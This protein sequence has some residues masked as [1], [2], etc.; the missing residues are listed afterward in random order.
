MDDTTRQVREMYQ[1][2]PYPSGAPALRSSSD[3]RL[4]LSYGSVARSEARQMWA[5]DAGCGRG[6]GTIGHA[7]TQPDINFVGIDITPEALTD[8][9]AAADKRN[10]KN[11][12]FQEI[13]LMTLE[14][15]QVPPG[16]FDVIYS[17]GVLHHLT[18][19][20]QGLI[21]LREVLAPHGVI[22]LMVYGS[23]GRHPLYRLVSAIDVLAPRTLPLE[24]RLAAGRALAKSA[25]HDAIGAGP[26]TDINTIPDV[27]FVDRYLHVNETSYSITELFSLA[28]QAGLGFL[29]WSHPQDWDVTTLIEEGPSRAAA[30][31]LPP[32]AQ[33]RLVEQLAWRPC[34]EVILT[35][36]G[37]TLRAPP[38]R[39]TLEQTV[40]AMSPEAVIATSTR[41]LW[42]DQRIE[43]VSL[44]IRHAEPFT[45]EHP[46]L[47]HACYLLKDQTAPFDG[48][49]FI[50]ICGQEGLA[51]EVAASALLEL[52]RLEAVFTPHAVDCA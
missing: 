43:E 26:W 25:S 20:L 33:A 27:E 4:L 37:N 30:L 5:L 29:R 48:A 23:S 51:P 35:H 34:L 40:F 28:E 39:A 15:L 47:A 3:V 41:N 46:A 18:N 32:L 11:I 52:V 10:I 31:R 9:R 14:G 13:D 38:V 21:K 12:R 24:E 44:R 7:I 2:F 1:R 8:A 19:P 17:S 16:G 6:V 50:K 49:S 45:V 42:R 36:Q 22:V